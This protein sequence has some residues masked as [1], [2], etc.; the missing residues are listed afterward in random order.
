MVIERTYRGVTAEERR[1][2]RHRQL[3]DATLD[4]WG[5]EERPRI[6]MTGVCNEAGLTER[7]FYES[8]AHL[9]HAL[10]ELLD[11]IA[12]EIEQRTV[13]E[14]HVAGDDPIARV[15][16]V[17][18]AFVGVLT[19]DPRRGRVALVE[20]P[21]LDVTRARRDV[22]LRRLARLSSR[23]ARKLHGPTAWA[24]GSGVLAATMFVGGVVQLVLGRLDG[25]LTVEPVVLVDAAARSFAATA[26]L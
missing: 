19:E 9:D 22:M 7:Y 5:S 20:A 24:E 13:T 1:A 25:S 11:E 15:R 4:I 6:T 17:A 16:A 18:A 3:L 10:V 14:L 8:F 21:A 23:E 12:T 2:Q 26:A